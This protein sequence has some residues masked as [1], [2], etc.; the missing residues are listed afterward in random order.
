[1]PWLL[2]IAYLGLLILLSPAIVWR[3]AWRGRY[4]RGLR[5]KLF[6]NLPHM[7]AE[8]LVV[9]VSCGEC[10]RSAAAAARGG[11]VL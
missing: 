5:Q 11:P 8:E 7:A 9:W 2:N 10:R 1:M 3:M 4:R 6:G